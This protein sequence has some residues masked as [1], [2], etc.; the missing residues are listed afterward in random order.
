[1]APRGIM[2]EKEFILQGFT[3]RTHADAVREIFDI[4][5]IQKVIVS[6]AFISESG[7]QQLEAK[8]T[9]HAANTKV[10]AG[11]RNDITSHQG[12]VALK[13]LA[14]DLYIVDTGSRSVLFHPKLYFA[15]GDTRARMV[16]GS[17]NLTLGGL[18]NNIEAGMLLDF[19]LTNAA[20][21]S[22]VEK[23]EAEFDKLAADFGANV[24]KINDVADLDALLATGRV[25]DEMAAAPPRPSSSAGSSGG[26]GDV[27]PRIKLKVVPL[28]RALKK[29]KAA[30]KPKPTKAAKKA[31]PGAVPAPKP[32]PKAAGVQ[33]ELVWENKG[34]LP[35]DVD[36][37]HYFREDI[38]N[39]LSWSV[40][41]AK[42]TEEAHAKFHLV[43]KGLSY[44]DFDLRIGHTM[45]TT[46]KAYK[47]NNA[48]TRLSWGPVKDYVGHAD[49]KD[50]TLS[51]FRDL[52]DPTR[53]VLEID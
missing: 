3:T 20:D 49:L 10:F 8:L 44:G 27:I 28:R 50:R 5:N 41:N 11:I 52:A 13:S 48:M 4:D 39:Q 9:P 45:G 7:V 2:A 40:T 29:A 35:A 24:L 32:I 51:L 25:I 6:V 53:F 46:S 19:D 43:I 15:K 31:A 47:Q 22:A 23:I 38:F 1:M 26:A 14:S 36:H 21:K 42:T 17:A 30:A 34:L 12:L 37:R 16:I 18:N 33:F